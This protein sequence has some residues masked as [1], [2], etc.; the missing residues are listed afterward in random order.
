MTTGGALST[1]LYELTM[2]AGY[3]T[4]GV[5]AR[6]TFELYVRDLPPN[7][8]FLVA[9]GLEQALAY[10]EGLRFTDDDIAHL[11]GLPGL[12]RVPSA[13]FDDYLPGFR[14]TGDVWAIAEGTP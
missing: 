6:A 12:D 1:D 3:Y 7:R 4:A 8:S 13:F 9:A 10:L 11:R 5:T 14:F 2:V